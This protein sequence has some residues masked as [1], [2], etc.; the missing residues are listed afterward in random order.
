MSRFWQGR[1]KH[2]LPSIEELRAALT[3][4]PDTGHVGG[5]YCEMRSGYALL[6]W[7]S[8]PNVWVRRAR[9]AWALVTGE[10]PD[11]IDHINGVRDDDRWHNLRSVSNEDNQRARAGR[12]GKAVPIYRCAARWDSPTGRWAYAVKLDCALRQIQRRDFCAL[13]KEVQRRGWPL[14]RPDVPEKGSGDA[15]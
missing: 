10:W 7:R 1:R 14:R 11:T 3:Y 9:V 12:N 8:R 6:L 2:P 15:G 4:D 5:R 13:V